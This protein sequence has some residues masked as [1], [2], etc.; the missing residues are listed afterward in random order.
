MRKIFVK[1]GTGPGP[2][3][4]YGVG[5]LSRLLCPQCPRGKGQVHHSI[6]SSLQCWLP[7]PSAVAQMST[8]SFV[9]LSKN[10]VSR[11]VSHLGSPGF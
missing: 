3:G 10:R 7:Y 2:W 1:R 6:W 8:F 5:G 11:P 9:S 4:L